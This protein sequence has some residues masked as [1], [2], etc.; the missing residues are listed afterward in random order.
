ME[1]LGIAADST[2]T[3]SAEVVS[4]YAKTDGKTPLT[5]KSIEDIHPEKMRIFALDKNN[6]ER[7]IS[8]KDCSV[9]LEE[10]SE[11][12]ALL[13]IS[14]EGCALSLVYTLEG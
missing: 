4:I 11:G 6:E 5:V 3:D 10:L 8:I 2:D 1:S 7:E 12:K 13:T 9:K 14:Y